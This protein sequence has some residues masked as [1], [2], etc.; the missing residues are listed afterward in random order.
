MN[1]Q[2]IIS[3]NQSTASA[4]PNCTFCGSSVL[5]GYDSCRAMFG[6]VLEREYRDPAY[7]EAHLFTVDAFA[8]QHSEQHGPRSNAFHLMR[9]CWLLEHKGHPGIQRVRRESRAFDDAREKTYDTFPLLEPP[10]NRGELTVLS[11]LA[12]Q[13]PREHAERSRAW[14]RSV[15]DAWSAH[16]AWARAQVREWFPAT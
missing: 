11:V 14:G 7:G 8:L 10:P 13:T 5:D 15:W 4:A 3:A 1:W 16:H 2:R 9:L 12:A 6:A